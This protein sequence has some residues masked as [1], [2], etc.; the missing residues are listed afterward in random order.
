M[1]GVVAPHCFWK[2]YPFKCPQVTKK[3]K[4][5]VLIPLGNPQGSLGSDL[6]RG[7]SCAKQTEDCPYRA[8][9]IS[10]L[11]R[12]NFAR[13]TPAHQQH[14]EQGGWAKRQI[15]A[16]RLAGGSPTGACSRRNWDGDEELQSRWFK[17]L[18]EIALTV[19][20]DNWPHSGWIFVKWGWRCEVA[21]SE[22]T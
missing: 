14:G 3:T 16:L 10:C 4:I 11:G 20:C 13:G 2:S 21:H 17:P 5:R 6:N 18:A 1:P 12:G 7:P 22:I 19:S 15:S 9:K 8:A